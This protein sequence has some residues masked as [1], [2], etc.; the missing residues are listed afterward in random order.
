MTTN[1]PEIIV[2]MYNTYML[3]I[4]LSSFALDFGKNTKV[5]KSRCQ[6]LSTVK[7]IYIYDNTNKYSYM[8]SV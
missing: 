5:D 1:K 3:S 8:K 2:W 6:K 4:G 7:C